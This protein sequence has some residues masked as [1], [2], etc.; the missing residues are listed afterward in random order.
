MSGKALSEIFC[1]EISVDALRIHVAST[2]KGALR[3]GLSLDDSRDSTTFFGGLYPGVNLIEDRHQ[4]APL[5]R[6]VKAALKGG[7]GD[8]AIPDLAFL[9][10]PFQDRVLRAIARIPFGETRRYGEVAAMVG[11]SKAA[12]AVGRTMAMNPLPIIFP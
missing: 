8:I 5:I 4:N 7:R 11:N 6:A 12:R 2:K 1:W 10:K 9:L 3:I